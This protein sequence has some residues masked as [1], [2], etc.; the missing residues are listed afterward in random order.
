MN[1]YQQEGLGWMDMTINKG[2]RKTKLLQLQ[3]IKIISKYAAF[4][5]YTFYESTP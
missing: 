3:D 5:L 2:L 1:G 4:I